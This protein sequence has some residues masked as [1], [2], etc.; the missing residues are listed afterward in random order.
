MPPLAVADY[1]ATRGHQ[2]TIVYSTTGPAPL[3][4]RYM[5]GGVLARLE[6]NGVDIRV[7]E[8]VARIEPGAVHLRKVY[9]Q[10]PGV[11]DGVDS[12]VLACGGVPNGELAVDLRGKVPEVH[13]L[14][15]AFAPRRQLYATREAYALALQMTGE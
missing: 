8:Q 4:S 13:V 1:L 5:I 6:E 12:V 15:D 10:L 9:S 7:S 14:G 3:L 2:V 11:I